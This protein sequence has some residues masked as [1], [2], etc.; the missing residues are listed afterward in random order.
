MAV[1]YERKNGKI[2]NMKNLLED[3]KNLLQK[4]ERL[5]S[6]GELLKIRKKIGNKNFCLK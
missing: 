5:V 6:G 2:K 4:D 1:S 3:L